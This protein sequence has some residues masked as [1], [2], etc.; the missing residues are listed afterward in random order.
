MKKALI[1]DGN[2]LLF[3]AY[4]ATAYQGINLHSLQGIPTNAVFAFIRMI[5][6]FLKTN[7]YQAVFVAFDAGK[8]TFR[9]EIFTS[10]KSNRSATPTELIEQ[11]NI[12]KTFL[13]L[14]NIPWGQLANYEADDLIGTIVKNEIAKD[15]Q[16]D[17]MS[18]DKDLYQL[19]DDNIQIFN[20]QKGMSDLKIITK[21]TFQTEY[22]GLLPEQIIDL[23][24]LMGDSSDNL[25]G[26]KGIGLK[27]ATKLLK[28]YDTLENIIANVTELNG[29]TRKL[30]EDNFKMG[31]ICK[32]LAQIDLNIPLNRNLEQ[33]AYAITSLENASLQKFY[34]KYDMKSLLTNSV[35][36]LVKSTTNKTEIQ[37]IKTWNDN[38]NCPINYLWLEVFGDNYH[39]DRIVGF[40]LKNEKGMFYINLDNAKKCLN[41]QK[42]L[43]NKAYQKITWDLK[44]VIIAALQGSL[45]IQGIIFDHMLAAY[46]LYANEKII[47]ENIAGILN[48][49]EKNDLSTDQFYGK[50]FIKKQVPKV[51]TTIAHFLE[52]NLNFLT[53][54][55][56][57][58]IEKLKLTNNWD[59]YQNIELP[60]AFVLVTIEL[61]GINVDQTQLTLLTKKTLIK[62]KDLEIQIKDITNL[63]LNPN[64]PKQISNYLFEQLKLPN[65]KKGSTA[66]QTLTA[67]Q[68]HHPIINVLI[69]HRKLQK[70]YSTYLFGLQKYIFPDGK[71]HTIYNQALTSTGRLSSNDPNMQNISIRDEEQRE[72]RKI[73]VPSKPKTKILSFDYSQIELRILADLSNDEG[74]IKAFHND[75]DI[76]CET[77]SKIFNITLEA[78]TKEQRQSAK[79]VN[80]GIVYGISDFGLANQLKINVKNAKVFINKYFM[81]FPKIKDY[82]NEIVTFCQE[83]GYVQTIFKRRRAVVE[84]NNNNFAIREFG[85]RI[86]MN[87]PI[88]GSAADILKLAM[89]KI[90]QAINSHEIDAILIAQIHDELI[91]EVPETKI[92]EVTEKVTEIMSDIIKLKVP[93]VVNS[94]SGDNWFDLK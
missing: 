86:A 1:I 20:P 50:G 38:W 94:S 88:Q 16:I 56:A 34:E 59:L 87:M 14:A 22:D 29:K 58:L 4:Y 23:K 11:F 57:M 51:E 12:V 63:D 73:F 80:F 30:I 19:L 52:S 62:I 54:S 8:Q 10:Y 39:R 42:F 24:A 36:P 28:Q 47:P 46:L 79:A 53:F 66:F 33:F 85:K 43:Q 5:T 48:F 74:L 91:F 32:Q 35:M 67:L 72:I 2:N 9:H 13:D 26:I 71:I 7:N 18:S 83:N 6:K 31:I 3:K 25:P 84:I 90:D 41:F 68:N 81:V 17:I 82:M 77:A 92:R 49:R 27:T 61:N 89:I 21:T 45:T 75:H 64:S 37:I 70:L 40:A 44:K 65:W 76:H 78:V 15:Y 93:L 55:H 60:L 69:E